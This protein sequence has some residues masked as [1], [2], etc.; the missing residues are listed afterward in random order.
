MWPARRYNLR[1]SSADGPGLPS[2]TSIIRN[3]FEGAEPPVP[4]QEHR[5]QYGARPTAEGAGY[6]FGLADG[7]EGAPGDGRGGDVDQIP[8]LFSIWNSERSISV[9]NFDRVNISVGL[10]LFIIG[11]IMVGRI[12]EHTEVDVSTGGVD[13]DEFDF[14]WFQAEDG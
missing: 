12:V 5:G 6:E 2:I 14:G 9:Q 1:S 7:F 4:A 10:E 8:P 13:G 3:D 11:C